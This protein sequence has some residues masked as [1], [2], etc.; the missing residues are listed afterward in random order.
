MEEFKIVLGFKNYSISN[1]G[2]FKNN[3][4]NEI[5]KQNECGGYKVVSVKHQYGTGMLYIHRLVAF[6]FL[7]NDEKK[8]LV[9]HIDG[10]KNNNNLNN[11]RWVS[12]SE[13]S[14][15]RKINKNNNTG[16]SGIHLLRGKYKIT[17]GKKYLG[18][19]QDIN[20]AIKIRNDAINNDPEWSKM[21]RKINKIKNDL[22]QCIE[23]LDELDLF[24]LKK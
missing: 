19:V 16:Y 24:H 13:N 1:Y 9:D 23:E 15:N 21:N 7:K 2:N 11:L 3:R 12:C 20:E 22:T 18:T 6:N 5:I 14:K 8:K 4:T 17:L 10:N